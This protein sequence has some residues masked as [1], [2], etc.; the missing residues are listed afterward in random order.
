MEQINHVPLWCT[1]PRTQHHFCGIVANNNQD[2]IKHQKTQTEKFTTW[3]DV[4]GITLGE[5]SQ[6][7]T[8]TLW[9]RRHVES[10]KQVNKGKRQTGL[11]TTGNTLLLARGEVGGGWKGEGDLERVHLQ[12]RVMHSTAEPLLCTPRMCNTVLNYS[13]IKKTAKNKGDKIWEHINAMCEDYR[14]NIG[15][16]GKNG[17][18]GHHWDRDKIWTRTT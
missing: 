14:L 2:L 7:E 5:L 11:L 17:C 3:M 9:F 15:S 13:S 18:K 1:A 4:E 16:R 10:N 12:R 6:T 8:N